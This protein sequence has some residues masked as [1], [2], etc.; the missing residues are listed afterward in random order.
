[1]I[2][3]IVRLPE[4]DAGESLI[5]LCSSVLNVEY[6]EYSWF[7]TRDIFCSVLIVACNDV[8]FDFNRETFPIA[9]SIGQFATRGGHVVGIGGGFKL[10]CLMGLLPGEIVEN[11][12]SSF[13]SRLV[14]LRVE[15]NITPLTVSVYKDKILALCVAHRYGR[16]KASADELRAM[17]QNDQI[18]FRYCD[19]Q[20]NTS[21][22]VN[23]DGSVDNIAAVANVYGNVFGMMA[24]PERSTD[25]NFSGDDG[26]LIFQSLINALS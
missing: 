1:M 5:H 10:L 6:I 9:R 13:V 7:E 26:L 2:I 17:R 22:G 11:R 18:V 12:D 21:M 24:H 23:I 14:H 4:A 25:A 19:A 15:N 3:G 16:F 20:G 8:T